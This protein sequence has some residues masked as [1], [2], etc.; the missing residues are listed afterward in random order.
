[1]VARRVLQELAQPQPRSL[2]PEP[3]TE[4]ETV[5]LRLVARGASNQSIATSL[6]IGEGTV[7]RHVSSILSK[8]NLDSRTQA[9]LYAL[10]TGLASLEE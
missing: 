1:V 5:V 10:R 7:R 4:R 9:T 8:L 6:G 2:S 3:L